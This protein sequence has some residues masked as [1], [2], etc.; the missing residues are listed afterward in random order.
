MQ[1]EG[2]A[3]KTVCKCV[4]R[5]EPDL[6][7]DYG[8]CSSLLF[9][10]LLSPP[11][12]SKCLLWAVFLVSPALT[13]PCSL[14]FTYTLSS[15]FQEPINPFYLKEKKEMI[16]SCRE[17]HLCLYGSTDS[18]FN[19]ATFKESTFV[20]TNEQPLLVLGNLSHC[21]VPISRKC[22]APPAL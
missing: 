8:Q 5:G 9:R 22:E 2:E 21:L 14:G 10:L 18:V 7:G 20:F 4:L 3:K 19:C 1:K 11:P 17:C 16:F 6:T 15:L 12:T 13:V